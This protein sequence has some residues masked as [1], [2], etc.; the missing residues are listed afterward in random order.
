[1][2]S[3]SYIIG[4]YFLVFSEN[5]QIKGTIHIIISKHHETTTMQNVKC[6]S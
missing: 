4:C 1:M 3:I 6:C 2:G 5:C